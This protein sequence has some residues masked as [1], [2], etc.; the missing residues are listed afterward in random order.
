MLGLVNKRVYM[1]DCTLHQPA[2][3]VTIMTSLNESWPL[4][5]DYREQSNTQ[6]DFL[7]FVLAAAEMDFLC[8]GDCLIVDNAAVHGGLATFDLLIETLSV[9]GAQLVFLPAYSPEL[10]PCEL[11]FSLLKQEIRK[12]NPREYPDILDRVLIG[13]TVINVEHL[14]AFYRHCIHPSVILPD[15]PEEFVSLT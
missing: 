6:W 1:Q 3:S 7:N 2:A 14:K 11:V 10:N 15:L 8:E 13:A 12:C 9:I 4:L 5:L